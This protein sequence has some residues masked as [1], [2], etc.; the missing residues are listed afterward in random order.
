MKE[1]TEVEILDGMPA[2]ILRE[3]D[4]ICI[5]DLHLGY[6]EAL[7]S[8]GISLPSRQLSDVELNFER[9]FNMCGGAS[10]LVINGDLKHVFERVSRQEWKEVPMFIDFA[11]SFVK[12]IILVRGN[13]DTH[14]GPLRRF[15]EVDVVSTIEMGNVL[16]IHGHNRNFRSIF[17][18]NAEEVLIAHEHPV[19]VLGDRVGA[20]VRISCFLRGECMGKRLWVMPA[21]SPL[22]GGTAVNFAAKSDF[23]S[24]VLRSEIV[25]TDE[26]E[27]YAVDSSVGTLA[28]PPMGVWK[29][30]SLFL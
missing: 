18:S 19:L 12:K 15:R 4:A 9:A 30:I 23:L 20:R 26:M 16:L 7:A 11:L 14:L 29:K 3:E 22:A 25:N 8:S 1:E 24:P 5:A 13:H 27:V 10:L 6:E 21:F 17:S 28:F 2:V